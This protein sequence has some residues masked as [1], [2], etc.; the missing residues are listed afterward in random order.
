MMLDYIEVILLLLGGYAIADETEIT[1]KGKSLGFLSKVLV[2]LITIV[3]LHF[4]R[5]F[6]VIG[7]HFYSGVVLLTALKLISKRKP[8]NNP[9]ENKKST[10]TKS[11]YTATNYNKK[12]YQVVNRPEPQE[13]LM[14]LGSK[15]AEK[16]A[17]APAEEI[18]SNRF[19]S[20]EKESPRKFIKN[21]NILNVAFSYIDSNDE[22]TYR[23]VDV[24]KVD[25]EYISGYCHLRS[26]IR[27]FRLDRI[28]D[29]EIVNL[30]SG[31]ILDV[32]DWLKSLPRSIKGSRSGRK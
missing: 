4:I 21:S 23:E 30:D 31:E 3:L 25:K 12:R 29:D 1:F 17:P 8:I 32:E 13:H 11:T 27:T 10:P 6:S 19:N 9:K 26:R 2:L 22:Y 7:S 14:N 5:E 15:E 24:K 28:Q 20:R 16:H 18:I